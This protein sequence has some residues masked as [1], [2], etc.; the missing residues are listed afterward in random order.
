MTNKQQRQK[1]H[2]YQFSV[3]SPVNKKVI[4]IIENDRV[5]GYEIVGIDYPYRNKEM[6]IEWL[7]AFEKR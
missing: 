6:N 1:V 3:Y 7:E 4:R 2:L 5:I